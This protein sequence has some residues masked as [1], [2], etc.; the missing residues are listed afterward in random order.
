MISRR[1]GRG[2]EAYYA[3]VEDADDEAN[4]DSALIGSAFPLGERKINRNLHYREFF[5]NMA[6]NSFRNDKGVIYGREYYRQYFS[7]YHLGRVTR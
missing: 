1:Q 3:Y 2:D 6:R 4:N 5:A 7:R